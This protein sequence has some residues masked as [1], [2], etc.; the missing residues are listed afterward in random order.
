MV[1]KKILITG[2]AGYVGTSLIPSLLDE[3]HEVT[4]FDNLMQGGNQLLAFLRNKNFKFIKGDITIKSDLATA[5]K[6][7]DIIVHLAAIVGFPACKNNP[8]LAISVNVE[9]TRNLIEAAHPDQVILYGSTGSNYGKVTDICTEKTPLNPLSLYGETKT[10]A[11]KLLLARGN[12][13]AYRF[14]T[15]FGISPRLRLDL[16]V[17][18]FT[19]KCLRDGYLVVYEKHFMR[20]FIHVADMAS[21]FVFA[22]NNIDK[23]INNVYN[24][25]DSNMNYSKEEVCDLIAG[26][27]GAFIHYAEIG[28]DADK[29]NY[30]VSY[31]KI[32]K[33]G[34]KTTIGIEQGIDE[35]IRA[36]KVVDFKDPYV[37]VKRVL[38]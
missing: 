37:N 16:L 29:R 9:G 7:H 6:G 1:K 32:N 2:G 36:L 28:E 34:F 17:N 10:E 15:A 12:V 14:A 18:D 13:V 8:E 25:G 22:I 5:V 27:T 4:V 26:K 35:I 38:K 23:M 21:S 3:G 19:N 20:T 11:E 24:V 33:L 30:I 31:E